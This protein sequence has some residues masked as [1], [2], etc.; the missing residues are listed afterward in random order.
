MCMGLPMQVRHVEG[1][2]AVCEGRGEQRK[3]RTALVGTPAPDDWLLVHLDSAIERLSEQRAAEVNQALDLVAAAMQGQVPSAGP[4]GF[5]LP[6][7]LSAS[8]L[9][10]L[11]GAPPPLVESTPTE[12]NA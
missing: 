12:G 2:W 8:D 5:A 9:A 1:G 6:S 11:T 3:V 7:A 10:A 4:A